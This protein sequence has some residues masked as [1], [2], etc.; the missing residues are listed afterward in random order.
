MVEHALGESEGRCGSLVRMVTWAV[1]VLVVFVCG[2]KVEWMWCGGG[3]EEV[4]EVL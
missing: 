3:V 1:V 2:G 4:E